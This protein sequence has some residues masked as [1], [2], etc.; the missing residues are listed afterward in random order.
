MQAQGLGVGRMRMDSTTP[1]WVDAVD[2]ILENRFT[3]EIVY[4]CV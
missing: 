1:G 2:S 3:L 4:V